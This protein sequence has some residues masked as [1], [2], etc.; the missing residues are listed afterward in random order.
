MRHKGENK[1][2][3]AGRDQL[4]QHIEQIAQRLADVQARLPAHSIPP[5]MVMEIEALEEQL[6]QLQRELDE[7]DE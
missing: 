5:A 4:A 6:E 2:D 3:S 1:M 7:R